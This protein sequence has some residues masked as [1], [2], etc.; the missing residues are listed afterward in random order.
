[1]AAS[2]LPPNLQ[3]ID[4]VSSVIGYMSLSLT[5]SATVWGDASRNPGLFRKCAYMDGRGNLHVLPQMI[6]L[7]RLW[8]VGQVRS[9]WP[10][11][12]PFQLTAHNEVVY[13]YRLPDTS[14]RAWVVSSAISAPADDDRQAAADLLSPTFDGR[15]TAVVSGVC[16]ALPREARASA[17]K[18][19]SSQDE[20]LT[21]TAPTAGLVAVSDTWY[22]TWEC[23]VDGV[24]ARMY[25][26]NAC[27]RGVVA[28]RAGAVIRMTYVDRGL[29]LRIICA[30]LCLALCVIPL[31][32]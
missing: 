12:A 4:G 9:I 15:Q 7:M 13:V 16:P 11:P 3:A 22:P 30:L 6:D 1:V 17:V 23:T 19:V 28:P 8:H 20:S 26:V 21:L 5:H 14:P 27:M 32:K 18:N 29:S 2:I 25:R 24:P 10:L 31:R